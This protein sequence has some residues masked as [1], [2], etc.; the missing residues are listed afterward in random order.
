MRWA[1]RLESSKQALRQLCQQLGPRD[2]L[3]LVVF[4]EEVVHRVENATRDQTEPLLTV[5]DR[6]VA[7]GGTNLTLGLQASVTQAMDTSADPRMAKRLALISDGRIK[8]AAGDERQLC[9]LLD[10]AARQGLGFHVL[11][12]IHTV[13]VYLVTVSDEL[14]LCIPVPNSQG[15]DSHKTCNFSYE[16]I[17]F[18]TG[19]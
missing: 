19:Y 10:E 15:S 8:I 13:V 3:S 7:D 9:A 2:R 11:D 12:L 16:K 5:L 1:D 14:T 17:L 18:L 6:L 4:N